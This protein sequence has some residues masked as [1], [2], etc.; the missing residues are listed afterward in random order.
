MTRFGPTRLLAPRIAVLFGASLLAF[1][2]SAQ[3]DAE[4]AGEAAGQGAGQQQT[5]V[6]PTIRT[7]IYDRL[8][9]A[10]VCMDEGDL[11]CAAEE[12]DDVAR[13]RDLN[14][15]EIAQMWNFRAFLYFEQD[16]VEGAVEAY[17]TILALP[18][19][20]MPDGMIQQ[21]M[22]N[23]ATLYLQLER[24]ADGLA[25]FQQWMDLPTVMPSPADYYLLATIHYQME[26]YTAG[27]PPLLQA[28]EMSRANGGIGE[29]GWWQ[30]L[31]V[32]YFE[33]EQTDKVIE[34]LTFL[35]ENWTKKDWIIALAGQLAS[36]E[37]REDDVLALYEAAY[38][39]GWLTRGTEWVQ[40]AS[41]HLNAG[42][43]Y[44]AAVILQEGLDS[45]LIDATVANWRLLAQAW[46]LAA[47]H[48]KA[49]PA[50]A[51]ASALAESGDVDRLL[52]QS[53]VRLARWEDCA[54]SA[55]SGLDRGGLDRPDL[56]ALM[57]GQCLA[58]LRRYDEA[59]EAFQQA[60]RDDR[61]AQSASQWLEY[62]RTEVARERANAEALAA[63]T[64]Q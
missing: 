54:E 11:V 64:Q 22:R 3:D 32:F 4:G 41:F 1:M 18:H 16:D 47:E 13:I 36:L 21:S 28:I 57:L 31:Y 30:L 42:A 60:A 26:N 10:Q 62:V 6:I 48:E 14:N 53:Y 9:E 52:A 7:H 61:S 5:K 49:L 34:T 8:S 19:A 27:I 45:G 63:A 20:D 44:K 51:E 55:Q 39:A 29:E 50:L 24:Y 25:T 56:L 40:L 43:P 59:R 23:L 37:G 33:T 17:E 58:N 46:Q 2:A 12:L 38:D 35:A 15:Y